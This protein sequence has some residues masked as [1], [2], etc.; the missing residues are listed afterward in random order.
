MKE[1]R[2]APTEPLPTYLVAMA[3]GP[4]DV[5]EHDADPGQRRARAR[6]SPSA[7]SP[8]T[9]QGAAARLRPRAH[10]ARWSASLEEYFG[11]AYPYEKLDIIAVP[12]F[13]AGAMENAGAI[14][15]RET[16]LLLDDDAPEE[17]KRALRLRDGPRARAPVVRRTS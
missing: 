14:T 9:G 10:R 16:L 4:L 15:F 1:V 2:F 6:R 12:D 5:V 3:V 11:I 13:A 8:R 7:A 17:Q